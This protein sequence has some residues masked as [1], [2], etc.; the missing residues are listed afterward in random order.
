MKELESHLAVMIRNRIKLYGNK[1]A[2]QEV[3]VKGVVN[4]ATFTWS[5]FGEKIDQVALSLLHLGVKPG[6]KVGIFSQNLPHW[7]IA[8]FGILSIRGVSVPIYATHTTSHAE[9]IIND[10]EIKVVFVGEQDQYD[11]L[12]PILHN[13]S[14]LQTVVV[15][16]EN[17]VTQG[18]THALTVQEFLELGKKGNYKDELN[19]RL[20]E[21]NA[22]DLAT[23][24]YTSGTT[25]DPK[26]VMLDHEN[27]MFTLKI[28]D[29]KLNVNSTDISLAFLPLSHVF[30]RTWTFY[31]LHRGAQNCYLRNPKEALEG[32]K[33]CQPTLMCTVPRLLEKIYEGIQTKI[34]KAP[35]IQQQLFKWAMV[36]GEK[37]M[38][39]KKQQMHVGF[40]LQTRYAI[41]NKLIFSRLKNIFGGQIKFM[42]CAGSPLIQQINEFF[43]SIGINI[44]YGYGLTETTATVCAFDDTG[45]VF[46]S[47]GNVMPEIEVKIGKDNEILVKGKSVMK[48]YYKKP[49]ETAEVFDGEWFKTGDAGDLDTDG[50]LYFRERIKELIKTSVGKY[51]SPQLVESIISSDQFVDQIAVFGDNRKYVSALVVPSFDFLEDYAKN[52]GIDFRNKEDLIN[53]A[54]IVQFFKDK[55]EQLQNNLPTYERVRKFKLLSKNFSME[56]NEITP[57]LKLKRKIIEQRY[58]DLIDNMYE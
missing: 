7:T 41:A 18:N 36:I 30:E 1:I 9:Y 29:Q 25:G 4:P 22:Q 52:N 54:G 26:G 55:I 8:D 47:I 45:F 23:L 12:L 40:L 27:F 34:A 21:A 10:A 17:V 42:P 37:V 38:Q 49:V 56:K 35:T 33:L 2:L 6:E 48:G 44:K 11:K 32:M 50:N 28:H 24:I 46:G 20:D 31:I 58:K 3:G 13:N 15:F 19:S 57:T 39:R 51:I 16:D 43:H 14:N 5:E 53:H